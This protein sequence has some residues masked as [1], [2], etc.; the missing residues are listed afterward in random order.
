[1]GAGIPCWVCFCAG[2]GVWIGCFAVLSGAF[3]LGWVVVTCGFALL[4][5]LMLIARFWGVCGLIGGLCDLCCVIDVL[6][7]FGVWDFEFGFGVGDLGCLGCFETWYAFRL[8]FACGLSLGFGFC[9]WFMFGGLCWVSVELWV[10]FS[11]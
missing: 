11:F 6:V 2:W 1:M 8:C 5:V 10:L 4:R 7:G 9:L 3:E